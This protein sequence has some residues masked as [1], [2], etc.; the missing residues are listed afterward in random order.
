[1]VWRPY[2]SFNIWSQFASSV[3]QE[4][5]HC[6]MKRGFSRARKKESLVKGLLEQDTIPQHIGLQAQKGIYKFHQNIQL[7]HQLDGV[8]IVAEK[9]KLDQKPVE[10]KQRVIK[11][12]T[13]YYQKPIL[14][15][16]D[17]IK[18]SRGDE[19][20]PEPILIQQGNYFFNLFVALDCIFIESDN[21]LHILDFKTGTSNFDRRQAFVYLLAATYMFPG[22]KAVASF[23]NLETSKWSEPITATD[24]QLKAIQSKLA[25]IA[26]EHQKELRRYK[27]KPSAFAE[28]FP[29]NPGIPCRNCQFTPICK[30]HSLEVSA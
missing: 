6:D 22:Q 11:I 19:G 23:Y 10:V 12:L 14:C 9:L 15:E 16:K 20:M 2:V 8:E 25:Q 24:A 17:I 26:Q 21:R 13:N 29:A 30:L 5:W 1:M 27:Q 18:L 7:L 28:I 3:G 4:Y